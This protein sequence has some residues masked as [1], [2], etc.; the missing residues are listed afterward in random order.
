MSGEVLKKVKVY[1]SGTDVL[2][3]KY[4]VNDAGV[5]HGEYRMYWRDGET[6][7][8]C[9]YVLGKLD[10]EYKEYYPSGGRWLLQTIKAGVLDGLYRQWYENGQV[11]IETHYRNGEDV[12]PYREWA[13]DGDLITDIPV[14][15]LSLKEE[16]V[17]EKE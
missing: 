15:H 11:E 13:A 5:K 6:K 3:K 8:K 7:V 2:W 16:Y 14:G 4:Y 17:G 12:G 1:Y 9:F 10:G